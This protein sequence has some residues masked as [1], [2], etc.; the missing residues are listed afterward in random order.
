MVDGTSVFLGILIGVGIALFVSAVSSVPE[1]DILEPDALGRHIADLLRLKDLAVA[2][3]GPLR[4][5]LQLAWLLTQ[6]LVSLAVA[7]TANL[8]LGALVRNSALR[9]A[10]RNLHRSVWLGPLV[11]L[12]ILAAALLVMLRWRELSPQRDDGAWSV[13]QWIAPEEPHPLDQARRSL[14]A[15]AAASG[16]AMQRL[17]SGPQ[18]AG[19]AEAFADGTPPLTRF[20][21]QVGVGLA[22]VACSFA[23]RGFGAGERVERLLSL[24]RGV[25]GALL[26]CLALLHTFELGALA[27]QARVARLPPS[28]VTQ[29]AAFRSLERLVAVQ[30]WSCLYRTAVAVL[31]QPALAEQLALDLWAPLFFLNGATSLAMLS[32]LTAPF[33]LCARLLALAPPSYVFW[34]AG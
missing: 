26:F 24:L 5:Y 22:C 15:V 30:H 9:H 28:R 17:Q 21:R 13:W 12:S 16:S 31:G 34:Q 32:M 29:E 20:K 25:G 4:S 2:L 18:G 33:V 19:L 8:W 10:P 3:A 27:W 1:R 6:Q 7:Y 23:G 11:V 14:G